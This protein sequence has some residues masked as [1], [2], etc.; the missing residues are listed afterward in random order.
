VCWVL[1]EGWGHGNYH[2]WDLTEALTYSL[3]TG[4]WV[5]GVMCCMFFL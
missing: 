2:D 4:G 5:G 1:V 3:D